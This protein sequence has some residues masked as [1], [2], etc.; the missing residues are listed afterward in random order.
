MNIIRP[1]FTN[2]LR[3]V[4]IALWLTIPTTFWLWLIDA[5]PPQPRACE[6]YCGWYQGNVLDV[7]EYS[8]Y[9]IVF[10]L[11]LVGFVVFACWIAGY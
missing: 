10:G 5:P 6:P 3:I 1:V 7:S 2:T 8:F 4:H 11:F 9:F